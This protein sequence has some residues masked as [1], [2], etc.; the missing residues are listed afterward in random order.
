M[1]IKRKVKTNWGPKI[2][3]K[4]CELLPLKAAVYRASR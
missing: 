1:E 4:K 3:F 2:K